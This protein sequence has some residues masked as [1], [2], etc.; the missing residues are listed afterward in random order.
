MLVLVGMVGLVID[1]GY[2]WGQQR[3]GQN[4]V[5]AVV[6][7]GAIMLAE[8]QPFILGGEPVPNT[9]AEIKTELLEIAGK[10]QLSYDEAFY[11]DYDGNPLP[12]PNE[13]GTLGT[14]P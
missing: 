9:D 10:N 6:L 4:G 7:A 2:A 11:T 5:D 14:A 3:N 1:G 8:N 13:V 12:G